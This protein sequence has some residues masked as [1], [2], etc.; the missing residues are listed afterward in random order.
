MMPLISPLYYWQ[1]LIPGTAFTFLGVTVNSL[2]IVSV[3]ESDA[4]Q[5]CTF[6]HACVLHNSYCRPMYSTI[7]SRFTIISL[8]LLTNFDIYM[9]L[10]LW[11]RI[12]NNYTNVMH[13]WW[14]FW[15]F[16]FL[17]YTACKLSVTYCRLTFQNVIILWQLMTSCK[18][19]CLPIH[20]RNI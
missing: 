18:T 1:R 6:L 15:I 7:H 5:P 11:L 10:L 12:I 3:S 14:I 4:T 19:F 2:W 16:N 20:L 13:L 17:L 8:C 9:S